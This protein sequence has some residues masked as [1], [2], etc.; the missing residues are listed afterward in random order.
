MSRNDP[1][2]R[3]VTSSSIKAAVASA[4]VVATL[5]GW[6]AIG[7]T[8]V[9]QSAA[10]PAAQQVVQ[11]PAQQQLPAQQ[12]PAQGDQALPQ[13]GFEARRPRFGE[14]DDFEHEEGEWEEHEGYEE[15]D[16]DDDGWSQPAPQT[17]P[18]QAQPNGQTQTAPQQQPI[19]RTR[20]SR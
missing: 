7:L 17:A 19:T 14:H 11:Q 1:I 6:A 20:S 10:A 2:Q 3:R 13:L 4:A 9:R 12:Q 15:G 16:D 18:Q 8:D 5:G